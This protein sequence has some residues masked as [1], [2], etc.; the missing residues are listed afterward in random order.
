MTDIT[1]FALL[2][3]CGAVLCGA[4][5]IEPE[6]IIYRKVGERELKAW[7]FSPAAGNKR[8]AILLFHGGA[9]N[10]GEASWMF[11]RAREFAALGMVA[12]AIDYRLSAGGA[13]PLAINA[14]LTPVD[15]VEDACAAFAWARGEA[16]KLGIDPKRVA[17]Y[18]VSAGG[19]LVAAAATVPMV[20]G[21]QVAADSRPDAL[22]LF[23]PALNV[24]RDP[25]F[26][27]LMAG[28]G[29][30]EE[31]S[32][33]E[34]IS[35]DLPPTLVIQG[36]EDSIVSTKD[37]RALCDAAEKA[38]AKCSLHVYPGVGHLLTRN[39]KVQ[40]RDFDPDPAFAAEGHRLEDEF[41]VSLGFVK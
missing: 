23:S 7:V 5:A 36:A 21:T 11:G 2:T 6:A 31:Y 40:F 18:G 22:L 17:G 41:L 27:G 8:P 16:V 24:A 19:H 1:R 34:F 33:A 39:L 32:P 3:L 15:G 25:Y 10:L 37:A 35:R 14:G 28:K 9:W 38:G 4:Q 26:V 13:A 20:R 30:A 12:I 29:N